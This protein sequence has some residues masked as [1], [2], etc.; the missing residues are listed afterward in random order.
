[1]DDNSSDGG[2]DHISMQDLLKLERDD[3]IRKTG[4]NNDDSR[5]NDDD[6]EMAIREM[7]KQRH[8]RIKSGKHVQFAASQQGTRDPR[9]TR[10]VRDARDARDTR[11]NDSDISSES[12]DESDIPVM[13]SSSRTSHKKKNRGGLIQTLNKIRELSILF[14]LIILTFYPLVISKLNSFVPESYRQY[15]YVVQAAAITG[16]FYLIDKYTTISE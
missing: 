13:S 1:M 9:D 2:G 11:S 12:S 6:E 3:N 15:I 5:N 10:G 16:L 14:A 7:G 4:N 8:N